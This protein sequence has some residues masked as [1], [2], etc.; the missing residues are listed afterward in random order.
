VRFKETETNASGSGAPAFSPWTTIVPPI[1][2]PPVVPT[3][4]LTQPPRD[5]TITGN[6]GDTYTVVG[7]VTSDSAINFCFVNDVLV[8]VDDANA[9]SATITLSIGRNLVTVVASDNDDDTSTVTSTITL[10]QQGGGGGDGG[11]GEVIESSD[12]LRLERELNQ[13]G[14]E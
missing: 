6:A 9:F 5:I 3:I 11:G 7:T 4:T 14:L 1:S 2:N 8:E 12:V 10:A 13:R